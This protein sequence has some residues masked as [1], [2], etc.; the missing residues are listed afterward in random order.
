M[1]G[2]IAAEK[3]CKHMN[4]S[5]LITS[6]LFVNITWMLY[7]VDTDLFQ[8]TDVPNGGLPGPNFY[9][10]RKTFQVKRWDP[11]RTR[12]ITWAL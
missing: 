3:I 11:L 9:S 4:Y 8:L 6:S 7:G 1:F 12:A 10:A 5:F 2:S